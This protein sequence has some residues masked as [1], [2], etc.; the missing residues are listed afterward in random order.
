MN[1]TFMA[2][3]VVV[4]AGTAGTY[5][6]W[7]AAKEGFKVIL[8]EAR[9]LDVMGMNIEVIHM[10]QSA[11]AEFGVPEP[12][13][14]E[15]IH[16]ETVGVMWSPDRTVTDKVEH[17]FYVLNMP[18]LYRRLHG[19]ATQSGVEIVE[20]ANVT[21]VMIENGF[22][23]GVSGEIKGKPFEARAS[24]IVDASGMN[25]AVRTKLPDDFGV[26]NKP[27]DPAKVYCCCLELRT[28]LPAGSLTGSN[29]FISEGGFWNRSYGDDIIIGMSQHGGYDYT[30]QKHKEF[31]ER[32][33]GDPGR[34]VS[35]RQ[36]M[37]PYRRSPFSLV[38]NGFL[39]V[40]D[41]A[42]QNRPFSGEGI[43]SGWGACRAAL[44]AA[45]QA[46]RKGDV[47]RNSLWGY[48][49]AYF[50]D[51]GAKFA[52]AMAQLPAAAEFN[53]KD[54]NYLFRHH[55]IF[56]GKDFAELAEKYEASMGTGKLLKM[57]FILL[58]GVITGQF[59]ASTLKVLLTVSMQAGKLKSHYLK[60]PTDPELFPAWEKQAALLWGE[61]N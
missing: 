19:Y 53:D 29:S 26:E 18:A 46:L 4:G 30:W 24:L 49:T 48:N 55:I 32:N 10:D 60:F 9:A 40:G 17:P 54:A 12:Q 31:R 43:I 14:P 45:I 56:N 59:Q 11:F 57:V 37:V 8:L 20:N 35:R 6:A 27:I 61:R 5:F 47:S 1:D 51:Q 39:V 33:W 2:D 28:D 15:L 44:P 25:G 58:W 13:P 22:L 41:A 50:H 52:A 34:L 23:C 7:Q 42:F 38:G 16:L 3:V 36:G 21:G